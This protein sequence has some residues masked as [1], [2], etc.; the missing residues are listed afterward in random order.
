MT[1]TVVSA[2][3]RAVAL[4]VEER[5]DEAL[6]AIEMA[7][8]LGPPKPESRLMRAHILG[9]LGRFDEAVDTYQ[10]L[11]ADHPDVIDGHQTLSSLLPQ[12]GRRAEALESYKAAL[13][14]RPD[15]GMLWVSAFGMAR[16]LSDWPSLLAF[17][18]DA[19]ARFGRD[20]MITVF[21]ALALSG[22]DR[23]AEAR[24]I[25]VDAIAVEPSYAPARTTLAHVLT[26]VGD[27]RAAE[28]EAVQA[29]TL[30]PQDQAAWALLTA[31]WRVLGDP[32]EQWLADYDR[33]VMVTQV[34]GVD[35]TKLRHNLNRR[36]RTLAAPGE[37]SLR[38]GTQTRGVLFNSPDPEVQHLKKAIS[39]AAGAALRQLPNDP[40]HPF[41]SRNTE[42][43]DFV[44]SWSVRLRSEGF[45][46]SHM[47]PEGWLSSALYVDLPPEV[48]GEGEAGALGFAVPDSAL[49]LTLEPR[50][51][52]KP[53]VG[54]LV[55]FPSY[56]WH[57]T[58]P[59]ESAQDRLT[60]AFDA[61]P[62]AAG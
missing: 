22:L 17:T 26:R 24:D 19:E 61:L 38:G 42:D 53:R 1:E 44:G 57:G 34:E 3:N 14:K 12:I 60:V 29:T 41:L 5:L 21:R 32:R 52:V 2:H 43:I 51:I 9:D 59:F 27:Y 15:V 48:G 30:T 16:G 50:R 31:I 55:I 33:D 45:H 7:L 11:L 54:Q 58:L 37:Q 8:R 6:A 47:H 23:D 35:W 10:K 18:Q 62:V 13:L 56:F 46:I 39:A 49:K 28:A 25:L 36:H 4:R 20:T 40:T